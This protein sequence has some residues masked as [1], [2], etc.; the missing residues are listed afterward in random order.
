V[1]DVEVFEREWRL[2]GSL[3]RRMRS[4]GR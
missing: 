1:R 2:D 3:S 4:T